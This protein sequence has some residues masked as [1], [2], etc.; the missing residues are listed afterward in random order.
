MDAPLQAASL[1]EAELEAL[2]LDNKLQE[3]TMIGGS[4]ETTIRKAP[5]TQ[6]FQKEAF[7]SS[8]DTI[9][10][11]L[12]VGAA[13]M[14]SHGTCIMID[15]MLKEPKMPMLLTFPIEVEQ[16]PFLDG[17][18]VTHIDR[19]HYSLPTCLAV[20]N[21]CKAFHTTQYVASEMK[22]D[23]IHGI[24]H[25]IGDCFTIGS[26]HIQVTPA[27][28]CWQNEDVRYRETR[29]YV[30]EDYCGFYIDT[31]DGSC[32]MVGDSKLM[33]EQLH[34]PEPDMILFD[35]SDNEWHITLEGAFQMA[36]VYPNAELVLIHWGSVDRP[37]ISA[38]NANP[39]D[40]FEHVV[41][42]SR[43]RI[44]APGEAIKLKR[45]QK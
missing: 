1:Q 41:N 16:I 28:H 4:M 5:E 23:G 35:F 20:A 31:P 27:D 30:P 34:M 6:Y 25:G 17:V 32:W 45:I 26:M 13:M 36:A 24:G 40:L 2:C 43:V 44:V 7:A 11:W 33:E 22:K 9:V 15:P 38:C 10:R 42:P 12:G 19:D 18:L 21:R 29:R 3:E 14:N 8:N 39:M 37:D